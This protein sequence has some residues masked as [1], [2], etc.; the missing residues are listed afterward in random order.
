MQV[1]IGQDKASG[2]VSIPCWHATSVA[3]ALRK[4]MIFDKQEA[5]MGLNPVQGH[6]CV[7]TILKEKIYLTIICL[8]PYFCQFFI[9]IYTAHTK[10]KTLCGKSK[11]FSSLSYWIPNRHKIISMAEDLEVLLSFK[12]RQNLFSGCI[13]VENVSTYEM[14]GWT[15]WIIDRHQNRL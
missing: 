4:L 10:K 9:K 11:H 15:S 13:E 14:P 1:Q 7:P 2:G 6:Q 5:Q 12:F 8:A 3:N